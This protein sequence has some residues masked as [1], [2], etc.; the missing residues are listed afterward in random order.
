[1]IFIRK[2]PNAII[3]Y[4]WSLKLLVCYPTLQCTPW[5]FTDLPQPENAI[6][7]SFPL[8]K[9]KKNEYFQKHTPCT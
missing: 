3:L 5:S 1:M 6:P 9:R 8:F 4:C 7:N 2:K